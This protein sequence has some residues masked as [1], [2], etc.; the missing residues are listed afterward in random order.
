[1]RRQN[2]QGYVPPEAIEKARSVDL[3]TY[4]KTYEPY[5]LVRCGN[6]VYCTKSHDSLKISNGIIRR[7]Y[8]LTF[9]SGKE[10]DGLTTVVSVNIRTASGSS[11]PLTFTRQSRALELPKPRDIC[12]SGQRE[13]QCEEPTREVCRFVQR[14]VRPTLTIGILICTQLSPLS[15]LISFSSLF[16]SQRSLSSNILNHL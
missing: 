6:N 1:M 8:R 16:L 9:A 3:L 7:S 4:L 5:E 15:F 13:Y 10:K 11:K 12:L 2:T 14:S